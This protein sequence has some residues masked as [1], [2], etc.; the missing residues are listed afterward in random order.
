MRPHS[1]AKVHAHP[2]IEFEQTLDGCLSEISL[3]SPLKFGS[4]G[5]SLDGLSLTEEMSSL[6]FQEND[7]P[8]GVAPSLN[9][10]RLHEQCLY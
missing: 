3:V 6:N 7:V 9:L 2:N 5:S 10:L 8:A 1:W 4:I